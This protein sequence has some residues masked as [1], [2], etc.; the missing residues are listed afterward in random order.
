MYELK[1]IGRFAAAHHLRNFYGKCEELH[2]HNW[3]VEVRVTSPALDE[4]EVAL[5]F[6]LIKKRL[7]AVLAELDH[8]YLN[9]L[10]FFRTRNPSSENIARFIF[11][12][13][14]PQINQGPVSLAQ[15]SAWESESACAT[16]R[17]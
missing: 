2:G 5:D 16:Y 11:E 9:D 4:A 7:A 3:T 12:R 17:P 8:K 13:L 6:G 14:A 1:V 15:V 10:D